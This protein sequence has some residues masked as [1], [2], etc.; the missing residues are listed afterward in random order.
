MTATYAN[1]FFIFQQGGG[2]IIF[3]FVLSRGVQNT[4][5]K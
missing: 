1:Y 4:R 3:H 2:G 5:N